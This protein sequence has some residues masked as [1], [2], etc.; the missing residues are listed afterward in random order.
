MAELGLIDSLLNN[1]WFWVAV[2][3]VIIY[4]IVAKYMEGKK[5]PDQQAW[6]GAKVREEVTD[7]RM[8]NHIDT[9]GEK[10]GYDFY[11]GMVKV[12]KIHRVD[13]IYKYPNT[14]EVKAL[15]IEDKDK[16]IETYAISFRKP[17]LLAWVKA[18]FMNK[19]QKVLLDPKAVTIDRPGKMLIL[20]PKAYLID[21]SGTWSLATN[22]E[23]KI[24]DDINLQ[25][26]VTELKGRVS[27]FPRALSNLSPGQAI[28]TEQTKQVYEEEEKAKKSRIG[29]WAGK[30]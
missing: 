16:V 15:A 5:R 12:G 27:D 13:P 21:D 10:V 25:Y 28:A 3:L 6:Y 1:P 17:G 23:K 29:Q 19:Y 4:F 11:R 8:A 7:K 24:I 26:D 18:N 20:D 9:W 22:K 30:K 2:I 14:L